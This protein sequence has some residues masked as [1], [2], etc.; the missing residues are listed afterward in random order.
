[1][2]KDNAVA[3]DNARCWAFGEPSGSPREA[4]S[5]G[6]ARSTTSWGTVGVAGEVMPRGLFSTPLVRLYGSGL[7]TGLRVKVDEDLP[8]FGQHDMLAELCVSSGAGPAV[9]KPTASTHQYMHQ[10]CG[11]VGDKR[12]PL[13]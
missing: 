4:T 3:R 2:S 7:R 9:N 13:T 10:G 5:I 11:P 12:C 8:C 6:V 1:M